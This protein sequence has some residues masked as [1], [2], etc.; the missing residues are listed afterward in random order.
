MTKNL[1]A[2]Q[3]SS[4]LLVTRLLHQPICSAAA[5][6]VSASMFISGCGSS[7]ET[8]VDASAA[9]TDTIP[10]QNDSAAAT[11]VTDAPMKPASAAEAS[12]VA[13][14]TASISS[15]V[16]DSEETTNSEVTAPTETPDEVTQLLQKIQQLRVAPVPQDIEQARVTRRDRNQQ[17]VDTATN[18]LRL[19]MNDEARANQFQ[20]AIGQL[21]DARF[22]MALS[23][24]SEDV[25]Q[26]YADVQALQQHDP[27]SPAAAQGVYIAARFAHTKAGLQGKAQ[28]EW[29]ET[30]SRWARE[31]SDRFP[32]QEQR[33]VSLLFA[34]ARS[35]ELHALSTTDA[36]LST[37]L[38]TESKLCYT[39]LA[40]NFPQSTPGQESIAVLR[41]FAVTGQKL[42]QFSGPTIDG[43]F[44]S[45]DDFV[46][47]PTLIYFWSTENKEFAEEILPLLTKVRTQAGS[48]RLRMIGVPMDEE[49]PQ[50]EAFMESTPVP[51]QQI[52]FPDPNQRSWNSQLV[53]FWGVSKVPSIWILKSD[54]TVV[55]TSVS[56]AEIVPLL[57]QV[58]KN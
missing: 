20:Q 53:R 35:C 3:R 6:G 21:L 7:P 52:Y 9:T 16:S 28:P 25:E 58:F 43:G 41:R 42:S 54:G 8:P 56:T 40:E 39:A 31:F 47:K 29:F 5:F 37:R 17:I 24:T 36:G 4:H 38:M 15:P 13:T 26:L 49:E 12:P 48:D 30:L 10:E 46:G 19:T 45:S 22:Q 23:G 1:I 44:V 50:L 11:D 14:I 32:E 55:S 18:V 33:A 27:K 34:A 57:Q 51:G 2:R